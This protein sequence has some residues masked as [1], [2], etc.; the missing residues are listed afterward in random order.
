MNNLKQLLTDPVAFRAALLVDTDDGPQPLA[1]VLDSWQD[2][3]FRA[4]DD[5]WRRVVGQQN[6]QP[7]YTR[8]WLE[9]PRGHSKTSDAA[10]MVTWALSA[11]RMKIT[12]V[13][14]ACDR[15]Q[16]GLLR[17]AVDALVRLNPWLGEL[18]EVGATKISNKHTGSTLSI[19]SADVASS[20]GWLVNF[21]VFDEVS[22]ATKPDLFQSVLSSVAKKKNALLVSICN[23]GYRDSWAWTLREKLRTDEAWYFHRL[24]GPVASWMDERTLAEQQ[25]LL[26]D[27]VYRRLWLNQWADGAGDA[28]ELADIEAALSLSGGSEPERG[29]VYTLGADIGLTHDATAIAVVGRHVGYSE[30]VLSR[31]PSRLTGTLAAMQDHGIV[32]AVAQ[33]TVTYRRVPGTERLKL[34]RLEVWQPNGNKVDLQAV[35]NRI[36]Q[37]H[38]EYKIARVTADPYQAEL[39][40]QRLTRQGVACEGVSMTGSTLQ[41]LATSMLTEFRE[42]TVDLINDP[43]LAAD[44]RSLR[45]E[46]RSY[47]FRLTSP[48]NAEG[49]T[50]HGDTCSAL[51]LAMRAARQLSSGVMFA[52]DRRLVY[53]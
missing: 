39:M 42:R 26:P 44:L 14:V 15:D 25:R 12:G 38:H 46:S 28:L 3:D 22:H 19:E 37:L 21:A 48:K 36:A 27:K 52:R 47:G 18:L 11:A 23:A 45:V 51:A 53:N 5:S 4:L 6:V 20:F 10:V 43:L 35:E 41:G 2:Q 17:N 33:P 40:L 13:S 30:P 16:A 50:G 29:Y 7:R 34:V 9:R 1:A 32:P 8:A 49:G 24:D 31:R